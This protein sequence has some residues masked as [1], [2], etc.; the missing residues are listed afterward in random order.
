MNATTQST[1][2]LTSAAR[3]ST[4]EIIRLVRLQRLERMA[5]ELVASEKKGESK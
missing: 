1:L 4:D 3:R 5:D 2:V